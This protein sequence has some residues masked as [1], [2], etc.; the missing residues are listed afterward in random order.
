MKICSLFLLALRAQAHDARLD[1]S[2]YEAVSFTV[3]VAKFELLR[4]APQASQFAKLKLL[5]NAEKQVRTKRADRERHLKKLSLS[6]RAPGARCAPR[7]LRSIRKNY[8]VKWSCSTVE[9]CASKYNRVPLDTA[10][11]NYNIKKAK[12]DEGF[13]LRS[14]KIHALK[15]MNQ[16]RCTQ[17]PKGT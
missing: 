7:L 12:P 17:A 14:I 13:R 8:S 16:T 15:R 11:V 5:R 1:C 4:N 3:Q 2:A 10:F 9:I 6:L